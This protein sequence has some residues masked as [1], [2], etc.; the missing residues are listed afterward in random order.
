VTGIPPQAL[1]VVRPEPGNTRTLARLHD[2]GADA[3]AFPL[4]APAAIAWDV[5]DVR[6]FDAL[7]VTSANAVRLAGPTLS[8]LAHLP[9]VAVGAE[10]A[11]VA[12]AAGLTVAVTG[13]GGVHDALAAAATAGIVRPLHL[14]GRE[15]VDSGHPTVIVY[16]SETLPTDP[17][18]F[19]AAAA[20]RIVLLHSVRAATRVAALLP[21]RSRTGIA[22]LSP[23]ILAAAGNGW[24]L[25]KAAPLPTD[26][27]LCQLGLALCTAAIDRAAGPMD[28]TA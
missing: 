24:C 5:P 25:A 22:A 4:F 15:H 3:T 26:A 21:D 9:V 28:K 11:A 23:A 7:L 10:S 27:A 6:R 20:D 12:E 16:A 8:A 2:L 17:A 14:A 1:L 18:A 19:A 13:T